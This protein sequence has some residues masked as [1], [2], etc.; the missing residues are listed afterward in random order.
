MDSLSAYLVSGMF[1]S[2]MFLIFLGIPVAI[3][4]GG[5]ATLFAFIGAYFNIF[6]L[7]LLMALPLRILG[8][9]ENSTFMSITYF[10]FMGTM[11]ERSGLAEN[12]F[13]VVGI[14]FGGMRGGLA[15]SVLLVG[16]LL[17]ATTGVVAA[18]VIP[19]GLVALPSMLKYSY[20]RPLA[21]GVIAASGTLGQIVPPSVVMII[22]GHQMGVDVSLLFRKSLAPCLILISSF[23]VYL[24]VLCLVVPHWLPAFPFEERTIGGKALFREFLKALAAPCFL[25]L[26]VLGTIFAGIATP[27]E[28]SAIGCLAVLIAAMFTGKMQ[29]SSITEASIVTIRVT[30]IVMFLLIGA[31]AFTLV[32]RGL[33]GEALFSAIINAFSQNPSHFVLASMVLIF[34]LGFFLDYFEICF[35]VLPILAPI[36]QALGIDLV[37]FCTLISINLQTSF[38]TPPFGFSL[39]YLRT[40]APAE[41]STS[42]IYRGVW[43]FICLQIFTLALFFWFPGLLG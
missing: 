26:V 17:S 12:L 34:V 14:A 32:F 15:F 30:G 4:L 5:V 35:I 20:H 41:V 1:L 25:I 7:N 29:R 16:T 19:L 13:R 43:P 6:Q 37:W 9:M 21:A 33:G 36:A 2:L 10:V 28:A 40:V 11:F 3:A 42:D 22:L 38:L 39:F 23:F 8:I 31:T 27:T 24:A 18:T